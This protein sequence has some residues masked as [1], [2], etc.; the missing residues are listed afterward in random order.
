MP[1]YLSLTL[2]HFLGQLLCSSFLALLILCID[3]CLMFTRES[4]AYMRLFCC[5]NAAIGSQEQ[6]SWSR[7]WATPGSISINSNSYTVPQNNRY[8]FSMFN[9]RMCIYI[10]ISFFYVP[11]YLLV[12]IKNPSHI[13]TDPYPTQAK[14]LFL[15]KKIFFCILAIKRGN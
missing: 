6:W 15:E 12:S 1:V 2:L 13:I 10:S 5:R 8:I 9:I 11:S 7:T 14:T 3:L 4:K